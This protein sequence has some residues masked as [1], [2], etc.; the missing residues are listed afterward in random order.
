[1][2]TLLNTA[3]QAV[4]FLWRADRPLTATGLAMLPLLVAFLVGLA[5]DGRV[6]TGAPVWLK[7]A[8]FAASIAIYSFTLAWAFSYLQPWRRVRAAVGWTTAIVLVVEVVIIATQAAR[9]TTSHFNVSTPLDGALFSIMG[10]GIV[11]QTFTS[12]AAAA[13]LWWSRF[14]DAA[15]GWALRLGLIVTIAGASTGGLMVQPTEAQLASMRTSAPVT[16]IGAHTV[17]AADGGPGLPGTG[18]SVEHGDIRVAHFVGLHA[19]QALPLIALLLHRRNRDALVRTRATLVAAASYTS[20]FAILLW[21][22]LRGESLVR[23]DQSTLAA[24]AA[25]A[26]VTLVAFSLTVARRR[27]FASHA[28]VHL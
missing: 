25:W 28:P 21:Q 27:S 8:K 24:L 12:V 20:L 17:G 3:N 1:M 13:A 9:G 19:F 2:I 14:D 18:W 6:V 11:L 22:A 4:R 26:L 7:P 15:M 10:A 16:I 5:V 23:P